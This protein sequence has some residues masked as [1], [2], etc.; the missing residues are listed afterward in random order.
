MFLI[1]AAKTDITAFKKGVGMLGYGLYFNTMEAIETPLYARAFVLKDP[2]KKTKLC[3]VNCELGFI[4]IALKKGVIKE[5]KSRNANCGF[6]DDNLMLTAQHTHSGPGGYSYYGLYNISTPG[7][8][9]EIYQKLVQSI[10]D[11]IETAELKMQLGKISF[12]A[13]T[14]EPDREVAFNRSLVQYNQNPEVKDKATRATA[15]M[16]VNREMLLLK[17]VAEDGTDI[18]E[19]NWFGVHTTNISND[20]NKVCSDNKGYAANFMEEHFAVKGNT[21]FVGAFAQGTCGDVTPK[22]RYNPKH[23]FQRGYWEGKF[24]NDF[25]SAKYNGSLQYQKALEIYENADKNGSDIGRGL[26]YDVQY[27]D[28]AN[29]TCDPRFANGELNAQ[30]GPASQGVMFFGGAVIDGPGAHPILIKVF[31]AIASLIKYYEKG[32]S[33][34]RSEKYKNA[35]ERK[36]RTQGAKHIMIETHSRRVLGTK[37]VDKLIA[38]GWMD[39]SVASIK[40]FYNKIG[41]KNKPWTAKILP[42]QLFTIGTVAL[43]AFPFEITTVGGR[44]LRASLEQRLKEQGIKQ[45]ILV[46]YANGYSGYVTTNEEYQVQMYEGGHTVFGEWTLAALQ[47]KFDLLAKAFASPTSERHIQHDDMPPD[48]TE[49]ELNQFPF[50]KRKW[51]LKQEQKAEKATTGRTV[52]S[53]VLAFFG[54]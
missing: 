39:P 18:G 7:F 46:P 44:R 10:A 20:N 15:H 38:P 14:F 47:T 4:T 22:F 19:I 30:T 8:V 48:F 12:S 37:H 5:L 36:Y 17:M 53:P 24:R 43:A 49:D 27:V 33:K 50:Y 40:Y 21:N 23:P 34:F 28:F 52:K 3:I 29:V 42:L 25:E 32:L 26:D 1:G 16:A 35:V 51:Y 11:C 54:L 41:Y 9:L 45:V 6:D 2:A 31:K 13:G